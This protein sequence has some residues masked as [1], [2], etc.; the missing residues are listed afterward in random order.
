MNLRIYLPT[1]RLSIE[2]FRIPMVDYDDVWLLSEIR[3]EGCFRIVGQRAAVPSPLS[4][5]DVRVALT[6]VSAEHEH[7]LKR[8]NYRFIDNQQQGLFISAEHQHD[9]KR[10]NYRFID[11]QMQG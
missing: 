11:N 1:E 5:P 6:V 8:E 4:S 9:L 3:F 7:D 2:V 10:Q